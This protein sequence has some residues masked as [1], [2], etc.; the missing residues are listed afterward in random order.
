VTFA[1]KPVDIGTGTLSGAEGSP[2]VS[3]WQAGDQ[4]EVAT[5]AVNAS[6]KPDGVAPPGATHRLITCPT[7]P[8]AYGTT[9]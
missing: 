9:P 4:L 6:K 8:L 7:G 1:G 2:V 3:L 5:G